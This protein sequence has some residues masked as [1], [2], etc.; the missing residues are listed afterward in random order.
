[1][2]CLVSKG[3]WHASVSQRGVFETQTRVFTDIGYFS[4]FDIMDH[5]VLKAYRGIGNVI[6]Q[7]S[8][9]NT[10]RTIEGDP[11]NNAILLNAHIDSALPSPGAAE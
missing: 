7:I 11:M 5:A 8:G 6:L 9:V 4:R 10:T 1:M 3:R 2:Q